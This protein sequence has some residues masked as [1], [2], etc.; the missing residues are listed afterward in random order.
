M[1]AM[2]I[3]TTAQPRDRCIRWRNRTGRSRPTAST[4]ATSTST[5]MFRTAHAPART[6]STST[7]VT[8]TRAQ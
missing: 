2:M 6:A 5:R 3:T 4:R 7:T 1:A 8:V